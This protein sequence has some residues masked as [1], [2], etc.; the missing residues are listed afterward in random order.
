[1]LK[2]MLALSEEEYQRLRAAASMDAAS[3][4]DRHRAIDYLP[5]PT[6]PVPRPAAIRRLREAVLASQKEG[7]WIALIG[8]AGQ[9]KS[10]LLAEFVRDK[11][12]KDTFGQSIVGLNVRWM[13]QSSR[14]SL[15]TVKYF[16]KQ[17]LP[18]V[19]IPEQLT[20]GDL[21]ASLRTYAKH[22]GPLLL[23]VDNT[24]EIHLLKSLTDIQGLVG[25]VSMRRESAADEL[26]ISPDR[27]INLGPMTESEAQQLAGKVSGNDLLPEKERTRVAE[28]LQ[29][30]EYHPM[31]IRVIAAMARN[32][33][34]ETIQQQLTD[35]H[36]TRSRILHSAGGNA[37]RA[38]QL[39]WKEMEPN[40][41]Q[42]II[43]LRHIPN[44]SKVDARLGKALWAVSESEA[45]AIWDQIAD[46]QLATRIDTGAYTLHNLLLS[47][48]HEKSGLRWKWHS[49]GWEWYYPIREIHSKW[50]WYHPHIPKPITVSNQLQQQSRRKALP[51]IWPTKGIW[52][53][54]SAFE[55]ATVHR[56][57]T[58]RIATLL[59]S[60]ILA[61]LFLLLAFVSNPEQLQ[62]LGWLLIGG[63]ILMG[64]Y[65]WLL[66]S[67]YLRLVRWRLQGYSLKQAIAKT[68]H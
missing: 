45:Q 10:T 50:R 38:F 16:L 32:Q 20:L 56:L 15:G 53:D 54:I 62:W 57:D 28:V 18:E 58:L 21:R 55:W 13:P 19:E 66:N 36:A 26:G 12:I 44:F 4:P 65:A 17:Q 41:K 24:S 64:S 51:S 3:Q 23:I 33:S 37:F 48:V 59:S 35:S 5:L 6:L 60:I 61:V 42:H 63:S 43:Q 25:V 1:M 9:G 7:R 34:W 30:V 67:Q 2:E 31:A 14:L 27:R 46:W 49:F 68:K 11:E 52:L 29:V 47:F 22:R 40:L 39:A 8:L